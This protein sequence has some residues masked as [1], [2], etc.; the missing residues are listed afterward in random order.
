MNVTV[1]VDCTPEEARRFLGLPDLSPVHQV[2]VEKLQKTVT[3]GIT[4]EAIGEMVKSWGP[5]TEAGMAV[6][7]QMF[8]QMSG[9]RK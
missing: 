3:D 2:Y 4:P 9:G 6:W 7:R 1:N 8:E 5:M